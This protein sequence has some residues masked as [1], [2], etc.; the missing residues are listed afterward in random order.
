MDHIALS[1]LITALLVLF[2]ASVMYA[3]K[4]TSG[5]IVK[6][7]EKP[8]EPIFRVPNGK[9]EYRDLIGR[10]VRYQKSRKALRRGGKEFGK[11]ELIGSRWRYRDGKLRLVAKLLNED[12][13]I[14]YRF[15]GFQVA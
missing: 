9:N 10:T 3:A 1:L 12:G 5:N 15:N 13:T 2:I 7:A 11:A 4:K 14:L 6:S 8:A